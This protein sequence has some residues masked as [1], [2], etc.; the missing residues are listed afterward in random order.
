MTKPFLMHMLTSEKNVSPFDVNMACDAGW[1]R[2]FAYT[3]V[4]V[5]EVT[6]LVQDA[7]FSRGPKGVSRTGMFIGGRDPYLAMDMLATARESMVPPFEVSVFA[8][9]SGAFTTA[10]A[11]VASV[12]DQL[13]RVHEC[14]L[15]G[16]QVMVFGGTG[17]VGVAASLL[18]A[19]AGAQV[20]IVGHDGKSLAEQTVQICGER[21]A[22]QLDAA[23][24]SSDARKKTLLGRAD[25][26]FGTARAGV[27]VISASQL[28]AATRLKVAGDLNAVPPLGI[29]GIG[30]MDK[31]EPIA[32]L[33]GAV[34][35]GA[36][37]IGNVKYHV[38]R[39]LLKAMLDSDRPLY[40][41]FHGAYAE[42]QEY[43]AQQ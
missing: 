42:A 9:P 39:A 35:L 8:D 17:P 20:C 36:L 2:V 26:V 18:A 11:L 5:S 33:D 4:Q 6:G 32:G 37:A 16:L 40:L 21:Y 15:D 23:D 14:T 43:A 22:V 29:E 3:D 7:I 24:G 28:Q 25:V 13:A 10:A 19:R 38:Q 31:G 27:Q 41:D 30:L 34:G 1:E 12:G